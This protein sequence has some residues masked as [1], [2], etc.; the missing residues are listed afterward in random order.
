LLKWFCTVLYVLY[1][2]INAVAAYTGTSKFT[3]I[4]FSSHAFEIDCLIDGADYM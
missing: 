2:T 3:Y 4:Y 1:H